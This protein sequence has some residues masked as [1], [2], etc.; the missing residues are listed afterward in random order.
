MKQITNKTKLKQGDKIYEPVEVGGVIY[1][2]DK[3]ADINGYYLDE[4]NNINKSFKNNAGFYRGCSKIVAQS[5][6]KHE[7]IPV[8]SLDSYIQKLASDRINMYT[9]EDE[10]VFIE[11]YKSNPNQWTDNDIIKTIELAREEHDRGYYLYNT[12]EILEQINYI[13]LI[14]IDEQFNIINL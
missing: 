3:Y 1:W 9:N 10:Q 13:E 12:E 2:G 11:G 8:I 5:Q 14:E 7:G 4:K 6:P